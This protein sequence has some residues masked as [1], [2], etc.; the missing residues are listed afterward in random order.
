[1]KHPQVVVT[2][3]LGASTEEAQISVSIEAARLLCD[4]LNKGQ[5]RFAVNMPTLDRAELEDLRL[6]LDLAW[7]L[8]TLHAQMDRG[9]LKNARV[10]YRGEVAHKNTKPITAS[11]AAGLLEAALHQPVNPANATPPTPA[12]GPRTTELAPAAPGT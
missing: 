8:G 10:T 9:T 6:Y 4:Y 12:R 7:R 3:H 5:V 11:F 1:I 2:P